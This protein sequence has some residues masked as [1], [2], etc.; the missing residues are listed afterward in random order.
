M[1]ASSST[2]LI[3]DQDPQTP[4][5]KFSKSGIGGSNHDGRPEAKYY[6][7]YTMLLK[8]HLGVVESELSRLKGPQR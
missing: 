1:P 2:V 7:E 3:S 6:D 4:E 8:K 5:S